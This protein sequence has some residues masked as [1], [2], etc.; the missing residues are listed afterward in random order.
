MAAAR[1]PKKI[2]KLPCKV[3]FYDLP[4]DGRPDGVTALVKRILED[5]RRDEL[6]AMK[7]SEYKVLLCKIREV[8]NNC[9]DRFTL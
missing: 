5:I 6:E 9:S 7:I 2:K 3:V 4:D 1:K 8:K